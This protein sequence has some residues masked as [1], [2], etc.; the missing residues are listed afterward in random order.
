MNKNRVTNNYEVSFDCGFLGRPVRPVDRTPTK[1]YKQTTKE[2]DMPSNETIHYQ[3]KKNTVFECAAE[4]V[5]GSKATENIASV[6]CIDCLKAIIVSR[7]PEF[8]EPETEEFC[9]DCSN[10]NFTED[11]QNTI[12]KAKG[13]KPQHQCSRFKTQIFHAFPFEGNLLR[14]SSC[15]VCR[16]YVKK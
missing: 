12:F 1:D 15:N 10:L 4:K 8:M 6:T 5:A 14:H 3:G 16:G 11:E 7:V 2:L 13:V 9:G